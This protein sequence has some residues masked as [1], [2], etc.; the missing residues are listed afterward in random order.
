[1]QRMVYAL[2]SKKGLLRCG[3][4]GGPCTFLRTDT[5]MQ[6]VAVDSWNGFV[7]FIGP[8]GTVVQA[9]LFSFNATDSYAFQRTRELPELS[10]AVAME[11]DYREQ[12][13]VVILQNGSVFGRDIVSGNMSL[14]RDGSYMAVTKMHLADG[15]LFWTGKK[16]GENALDE[17]CFYSEEPSDEGIHFSRYLLTGQLVDF[18]LV[19]APFYPCCLPAP[20]HIG[21]MPNGLEARVTW[22]LL[23]AMAYQAMGEGWRNVHYECR[24][25][26][27]DG[28]LSQTQHT[29]GNDLVF[30]LGAAVEYT[31]SVR[32]CT[33]HICSPFAEKNVTMF[34]GYTANPAYAIQKT[35]NS[36]ETLDLLG[37]PIALE[38][39]LSGL[40]AILPA[41]LAIDNTTQTLYSTA[42]SETAKIVKNRLPISQG[43]PEAKDET[44]VLLEYFRPSSAALMASRALLVLSS[45]YE[46]VS[47]R[48]T[49]TLDQIIYA[50]SSLDV[51]VCAEVIAVATDE[52]TGDIF[53]LTQLSNGTVQLYQVDPVTRLPQHLASSS[54][55]PRIS[56]MAVAYDKLLLLTADEGRVG[57]ID[58]KLDSLDLNWVVEGISQLIPIWPTSTSN[59]F[60]FKGDVLMGEVVKNDL[61]WTPVTPR[62][63]N[64]SILYQISIWRDEHDDPYRSFSLAPVYT[65]PTELLE[66]WDSAQVFSSQVT[67]MN[68]WTSLNISKSGLVAPTKPPSPPMATRIFATQQKMVDGARAIIS[69]FWGAPKE[70][71]GRP[72]RYVLNCTKQDDGAENLVALDLPPAVTYYSFAVKSGKVSCAVAAS[73]E[74]SNVGDFSAPLSID[75]SELR[76]LV[77]LFAIDSSNDLF[78]VPNITDGY[79]A[80]VTREQRTRREKRQNTA[81]SLHYQAM[82]F[83]ETNLYAVGLEPGSVHPSLVQLDTNNISSL[84]HKVSLTGDFPPIVA[85]ASDWVGFRLLL[86][87]G[88]ALYQVTLDP[89]LSS[90]ILAPK[91]LADLSLGSSDPKQLT[92]DPFTSTAFIL[93]LNGSIFSYDLAKGVERNL[94]HTVLCL[95]T[96]TVTWMTTE[97]TWNRPAS[98]KIYALT[99]NGILEIE[100]DGRCGELKSIDWTKFGERGLKSLNAFSIA[101]KM[102]VFSSPTELLLYNPT[103]TSI[104]PI[105]IPHPPLRQILAA[106]QSSQPYP[107]RKCFSL[108]ASSQI[109]FSVH[110]EGRTGAAVRID[111][112]PVV[113]ACSAI[114][115]PTTVYD[116]FFNRTDKSRVKH[117]ESYADQ[118]HLEDGSLDKETDYTVRVTWKNR[119]SSDTT[120]SES[121]LFRTGFGYPSPPRNLKAISV[122]PD[123]ILL[124]WQLPETLNGPVEEVKYKLSQQVSSLSPASIAVQPW[125]L[126]GFSLSTTDV[127]S[128]LESPC[129]VKISNLRA[130][131]DYKFW[132]IAGTLRPDNVTGSSLL[133]RWNSLQPEQPPKAVS[134]QFKESGGHG[135]WKTPKNASFDP[136]EIRA[137]IGILIANLLSATSYDYRFVAV[138]KGGFDFDSKHYDYT[139]DYFQG[140]QQARTKAGTPTEPQLVAVRQ[141]PDGWVVEWQPPNSDGGSIITSYA[142]EMRPNHTAEWEIAERGLDGRVFWWRPPK[143]EW[144]PHWQFRVRAANQEGFGPYKETP[145]WPEDLE[146][147][148]PF[149]WLIGSAIA[150]ALLL[151][152]VIA[153]FLMARRR[154]VRERQ[155]RPRVDDKSITL[156]A[157]GQ[158]DAHFGKAT[159]EMPSQI[160]H[161]IRNLPQIPRDRIR[162]VRQ[163]G[164]GQFGKV[165][166]GTA[167]LDRD[168]TEVGVAIKRLH[169]KPDAETR[170][171]FLKEA[172]LMNNFDHPN[173]VRLVG[174]SF[175]EEPQLLL[176]ELIRPVDEEPRDRLTIKE[177]LTMMMDIGRGASYLEQLRHVHRDLA[178]RNCLLT[179][180]KGTRHA[181][182]GDFGLT[183]VVQGNDY[184]QMRGTDFLPF[185]WLAPEAASL[186]LFSS[187]SDVWSYGV[188][189]WEAFTLGDVPHGGLADETVHQRVKSGTPLARPPYCPESIYKLME[190]CWASEA[191]DRPT[192]ATLLAE[193]DDLRDMPEFQNEKE[194]Y[195]N[196]LLG[197]VLTRGGGGGRV[198]EA[199]EASTASSSS[200]RDPAQ[201]MI[202]AASRALEHAKIDKGSSAARR[203]GRPGVNRSQR[204]ERTKS[205]SVPNE[206][207]LDPLCLGRQPEDYAPP[208]APRVIRQVTVPMMGPENDGFVDEGNLSQSW[209]GGPN[210]PSHAPHLP[211]S[212]STRH[213][214][215][216]SSRGPLDWEAS[217]ASRKSKLSQVSRV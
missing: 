167:L 58:R 11:I 162:L 189:F 125:T 214:S 36:P 166:E 56:Q 1:M 184:W 23:P 198:N 216:S 186:G 3:M 39:L 135:E 16:C 159:R 21:F 126:N 97:F 22:P 18:S 25:E 69:F 41:I 132:D 94:A 111:R 205:N 124:F 74:P 78:A 158:L 123:T 130:S 46:L 102:F 127:V 32:G 163:V 37:Q 38:P 134:I 89:F 96:E 120:A 24:L 119:W 76:P 133:L 129:R 155:R 183:R 171:K 35:G 107:D 203:P 49:G 202:T 136:R 70:W 51:T 82:A 191:Q 185:R 77:R 83:I 99:W 152:M 212:S 55:L 48:I 91:K 59:R 93:T 177:L 105:P 75:S 27:V 52:T 144:A 196:C 138:Y 172:I 153:F 45:P 178:A 8:E 62:R 192:F 73:N 20:E 168:S 64:G 199:F 47:Y 15:R 128:C 141:N 33:L 145:V 92:Y 197:P 29:N 161:E 116:I 211:S 100:L 95:A 86:L 156:D 50:C 5:P 160:A 117:I 53:Y 194:K 109:S 170:M 148:R 217:A 31:V 66:K 165:F 164:E 131:T 201:R 67:A 88:K 139:E 174:V 61:T 30:P 207:D 121:K 200:E 101:D 210:A 34:K 179:S 19:S 173:I 150:S 12:Q 28:S 65:V 63:D 169:D 85:M 81:P 54:E 181:K 26:A 10:P 176:L 190:S 208:P 6:Y 104:H 122:T 84:Q 137:S 14:I 147:K 44:T 2:L 118:Y 42:G 13:L 140:I 71:N 90:A 154:Q 114:S 87:M 180:R 182:I 108:P 188:L 195:P 43:G 215:L 4:D 206:H 213:Q 112:P 157:I 103:D 175:G 193:I 142:L 146:V 151:I 98:P 149:P 143:P 79:Q 106:S 9:E 80:R 57:I 187:K 72:L 115:L 209:S 68:A 110:N 113:P 40:P 7:Y 60:D 204:A 17:V